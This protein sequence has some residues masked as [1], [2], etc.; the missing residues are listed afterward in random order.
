VPELGEPA[1]SR[2]RARRRR[3]SLRPCPESAARGGRS[4]VE[5]HDRHPG[6]MAWNGHGSSVGR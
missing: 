3:S 4:S 5:P 6:G 1:T 2:A